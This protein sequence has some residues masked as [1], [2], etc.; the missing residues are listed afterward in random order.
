MAVFDGKLFCGTLPSGRVMSLEAGKSVTYDRALSAGWHHLAAVK[1]GQ[2][3]KLY[4]DG[5]LVSTSTQFDPTE[6]D[7]TTT[8]PLKIGF[9]Q[10][11]YFNGKMKHIKLFVRP[12]SAADVRRISNF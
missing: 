1:G 4:V 5:Q 10:H 2:Q 8:G 3:L 7:L 12:L 9:G 11:D 6:Y